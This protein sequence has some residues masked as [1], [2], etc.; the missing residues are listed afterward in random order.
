MDTII[1]GTPEWHQLR[2]GKVTASRISDCIAQIKT[3]EAASRS[4]YRTELV[5]E[6]LTGKSTEGFTNSHMM[7]GTELEPE[8]R[9]AYEIDKALFVAEVAFVNHPTIPMSGASPDGLVGDDGLVEIKCP[10]P[11]THIKYLLDGRV[12]ARY[13]NQM[14]WQMACTGRQWVDFMSYCPELPV[15]MQEFI[16]R[17]ERDDDL[18]AE[19]ESKVIE[20]NNEVDQVITRLKEL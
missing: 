8:A 9:I 13:K 14:A 12:P 20:F 17:Y 7:R 15:N 2:L 3:G 6:R 11:K 10:A 1:Q 4:D 5:T 16:C 19:L 18:I